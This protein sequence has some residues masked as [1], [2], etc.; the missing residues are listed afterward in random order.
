MEGSGG[1][2]MWLRRSMFSFLILTAFLH[3]GCAEMQ[4]MGGGTDTLTQLLS[5]QL[6]VTSNQAMG[7]TG[8][9]LSLAKERLSGMDFST[10]TKFIP[11]SDTFMKAA[12]DLGAVTGPVGDQAGLTSAFSRLGMGPDMVP[13]FTQTLS[14]FVGK[15]GGEPARNLVAA[16]VK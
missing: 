16:G 10:L 14:D 3:L 11:G 8:S 6:G 1:I 5:S 9:I 15:A 12:R 2:A 4:S 7:G 13:K